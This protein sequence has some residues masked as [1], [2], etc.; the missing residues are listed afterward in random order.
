MVSAMRHI[1][2]ALLTAT[3]AM[4]PV[5]A[6]E[7]WTLATAAAQGPIQALEKAYQQGTH[8][9]KVQFDTS[10]NIA[11]RLAAGE[12]P[13]VLVAQASAVEQ[14][15]KEGRAIADSRAPLERSASGL[16]WVVARSVPMS[17]VSTR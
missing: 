16:P 15:I 8:A 14:L 4:T 6:A 12:A 9:V 10:P 7:V 11:K 5:T 2:C 17:R 13:D 3:A 1:L